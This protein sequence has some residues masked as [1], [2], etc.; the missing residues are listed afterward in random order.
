[1][2]GVR[3]TVAEEGIKSFAEAVKEESHGGRVLLFAEEGRRGDDAQAALALAGMRVLRQNPSEA[4]LSDYSLLRDKAFPEEIM[5]VVGMGGA[6]QME[7]A[8]TA[9][10]GRRISR[11]LYPTDLSALCAWEERSFFGTKGS[12]VTLRT[13]GHRVLFDRKALSSSSEIRAGLGYL[14]ARVVEESDGIYE[15]L[16]EKGESPASS[17][18]LLKERI[19]LLDDLRE[20]AGAAGVAEAAFRLFGEEESLPLSGSVH[21]FALVLAKSGYGLLSDLLFPAAYAIL[22]LYEHFLKTLPLEHCPPSDRMRG[23]EALTEKCGWDGRA[24]YAEMREYAEGYS[25]RARKTAEYR[26]DFSEC[27]CELLPLARLS[28]LYRRADR[29]KGTRYPSARELLSLL[30]LTGE[31]VSGYPLLK[32]IKI[33]GLSDPLL[34]VG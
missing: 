31:A 27:L 4:M 2:G 22:R 34:K 15:D 33:T 8:K 9:G 6:V 24:L 20:E 26:E 21:T 30:S 14:L 1:M 23:V 3:I 28:R 5:A 19:S 32:H 13:E 29:G 18:T 12:F 7:A 25:E 10:L 17:L 11:I 16:I